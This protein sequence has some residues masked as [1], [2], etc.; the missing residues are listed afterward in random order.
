MAD[1]ERRAF[2][3]AIRADWHAEAPRLIFADWLEE[4]GDAERAAL[5]RY[6]C[7][8]PGWQK[9]GATATYFSPA[10]CSPVQGVMYQ[11]GFI[12]HIPGRSGAYEHQAE[13]FDRAAALADSE[14]VS[15]LGDVRGEDLEALGA[16]P[17]RVVLGSLRLPYYGNNS[18]RPFVDA[19]PLLRCR[20]LWLT[21]GGERI[22][23]P[24]HATLRRLR[25]E[26]YSGVRDG[27]AL[28]RLLAETDGRNLDR[29]EISGGSGSVASL[30]PSVRRHLRT[31]SF[32]LNSDRSE[33]ALPEW[34]PDNIEALEIFAGGRPDVFRLVAEWPPAANLR[35]I[36]ISNHR[37]TKR[38][39][40]PAADVLRLSTACPRLE[41]L[42]VGSLLG[43][44]LDGVF[45]DADAWPHLTH[46]RIGDETDFE[47]HVARGDVLAR[48]E[49]FE[50]N[51]SQHRQAKL[52]HVQILP[53]LRRH[54][55]VAL[56][57]LVLP[58]SS[59]DESSLYE[60]LDAGEFDSLR[61]FV[62]DGPPPSA[63][64]AAALADATHL[65]HLAAVE[66]RDS[67]DATPV[68]VRAAL[69]AWGPRCDLYWNRPAGS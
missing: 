34:L 56:T 18:L 65:R 9:W 53:A 68:E 32:I 40:I 17:A 48:L 37:T 25:I 7:A 52:R 61:H 15:Q 12:D 54:R 10:D 5:I 39:P 24:S 11:G 67:A 1:P 2:L 44:D 13:Y 43:D 31:L 64:L 8:I 45:D 69:D 55:S 16:H 62:I 27:D 19:M 14:T 50:V 33:V 66:H 58:N 6:Q 36:M 38:D 42:A 29:L 35:R 41:K 20:D 30:P 23:L 49:R 22:T 60:L 51:L 46:L 21:C 59:D 26:L 63:G 28:N 3:D 57:S 4:N 47:R